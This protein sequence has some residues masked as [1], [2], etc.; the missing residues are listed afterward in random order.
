MREVYTYIQL[1]CYW[2]PT[3]KTGAL[4]Q[5]RPLLLAPD[6]SK[7]FPRADLSE[8][9][10][11]DGLSKKIVFFTTPGLTGTRL[12]LLFPRHDA[13]QLQQERPS[14]P[15]SWTYCTSPFST[16]SEM[17]TVVRGAVSPTADDATVFAPNQRSCVSLT[18][19][20]RD[21]IFSQQDFR[22][23]FTFA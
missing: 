2:Y 16:T 6:F 15:C 1:N 20:L 14:L 4:R 11:A 12:S 23:A 18:A 22:S 7:L 17:R 21:I 19:F 13:D 5:S 3:W 8:G 10:L 9:R